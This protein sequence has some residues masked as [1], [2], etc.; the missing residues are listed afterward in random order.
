MANPISTVITSIL[1]KS[2]RD[3]EFDLEIFNKN[4]LCQFERMELEESVNNVFPT[5]ALIIRDTSDIIT[6]ISQKKIKSFEIGFENGERYKWYITSLT[7]ANNAASEIDQSFVVIYFT[8]SIFFESQR[9]SF[10]DEKNIV[11][12]ENGEEQ[13]GESIPLFGIP[14]PFM[15][16]PEHIIRT[17]GERAVFSPQLTPPKNSNTPSGQNI[18]CGVNLFIKN[19]QKPTNYVLFRPRISDAQRF[20][21]YQTNIISYLNYIFTYAIDQEAKKPYFMFWTDFGNCLNYKY[22]NLTKDLESGE[23]GVDLPDTDNGKIEVFSVYASDNTDQQVEVEGELVSSKKIYVLVT[24][25]AYSINEKNYYY[26]RSSPIYLENQAHELAGSTSSAERLMSPFLSESA[27]TTLTTVTSYTTNDSGEDYL[28]RTSNLKDSNLVQLQ[29][30]GYYGYAKDFTMHNN[31][32]TVTDAVGSY[33][34]LLNYMK[35]TPLALRDSF[36]PSGAQTPLYPF[37]DNKYIWQFQYD[38]T[39]T[40]PNIRTSEENGV[41]SNDFYQ[42][43]NSVLQTPVDGNG[44]DVGSMIIDGILKDVAFNKVMEAK[45]TAMKEQDEYDNYRRVLLEKAEKENFISNVLCCMGQDLTS[46]NKEEWFFA[47]ITGYIKDYRTIV[48]GNT[49]LLSRQNDTAWLYSWERLEP[50][51]LFYGLSGASGDEI[52]VQAS[53]HNMLHGWTTNPCYGS[54][55]DPTAGQIES[56]ASGS[57]FIGMETWAIN[58]NERLNDI[59]GSTL[60]ENYLGPGYNKSNLT[61]SEFKYKPIGYKEPNYDDSIKGEASHPVKMYK[62]P[63][64][65]LRQMGGLS[66]VPSFEGIYTYYFIAENAVDGSC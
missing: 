45:Y 21:Q 14:Y 3:S 63:T 11:V 38:I 29:D 62:I 57:G 26:L 40:H 17:Y 37:N 53:Y 18:G 4:S 12:D 30:G 34:N 19:T 2:D 36:A 22:F 59:E 61:D 48:A 60:F 7:Y 49:V 6:Y 47:K 8:N 33:E 32:I 23:F 10:Y 66:P 27:N 42:E 65:T 25:P 44:S 31:P 46:N 15:T 50:G 5:G 35:C 54:T 56:L 9:A 41:I 52:R 39:T 64:N 51:P 55:G 28:L 20:E 24:N 16:T 1:L 13:V 58:L 43:I